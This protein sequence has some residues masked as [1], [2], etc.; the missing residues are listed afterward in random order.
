MVMDAIASSSGKYIISNAAYAKIVLHAAKFP[1]AMV[2]G[3]ALGSGQEGIT[4]VIMSLGHASTDITL[5]GM[6]SS[7]MAV[8]DTTC[9]V[10]AS[11]RVACARCPLDFLDTETT[12][13]RGA[14]WKPERP[15]E[16]FSASPHRVRRKAYAEPFPGSR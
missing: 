11:C 15:L 3:F 7:V 1:D 8:V 12:S 4:D 16:I 6:S 5:G 10:V 14:L 2:G 13:D 9:G